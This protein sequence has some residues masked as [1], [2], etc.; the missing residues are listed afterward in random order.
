MSKSRAARKQDRV[1][2]AKGMNLWFTVAD[3]NGAYRHYNAAAAWRDIIKRK[4]TGRADPYLFVFTNG[5]LRLNPN[6]PSPKALRRHAL[7]VVSS[8]HEWRP[9]Q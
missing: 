7:K 8:R 4:L 6:Q 2:A 9:P 1:R 5:F 3:P